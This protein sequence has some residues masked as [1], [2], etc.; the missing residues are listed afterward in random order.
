MSVATLRVPWRRGVALQQMCGSPVWDGPALTGH[1]TGRG[2]ARCVQSRVGK[3]AAVSGYWVQP[4]CRRAQDTTRPDPT[5][6]TPLRQGVDAAGPTRS[7]PSPVQDQPEQAPPA[8]F[9]R[10][11]QVRGVAAPRVGTW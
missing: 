7:R 3:G 11:G 2:G 1:R 5:R 9:D 4:V 8:G 6:R 10:W